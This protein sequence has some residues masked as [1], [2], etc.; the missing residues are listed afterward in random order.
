MSQKRDFVE[1]ASVAGA[2]ISALCREFEVSRQTGHKWLKR[3]K[4]DGY[5]GL[6]EVTRRPLSTPLATAEDVVVAI[7][8][9]R[10]AHP[11]WG[12]RKLVVV[13]RKQLGELAPSERTIARVIERFGQVRKRAKRRALSIV[14]RAPHVEAKSSNDVWTIDFKGWWRTGDG[15]RSEPLTVRD[16]YSRFVLCVRLMPTRGADVRAALEPLFRKHGVPRAIQCDNGTPFIS[17]ASP[18]GLT[19]LSAWWVSLGI[20]VA[21]SRPGCPQ[22]N[23]AHERMHRDMASDL[24]ASPSWDARR[25]QRAC[26]KWRQDF[27]SMRPHEALKGKTP[28]EVYTPRIVRPSVQVPRYQGGWLIRRVL[29]SGHVAVAGQRYSVGCALRGHLVAL[30]PTGGLAHRI[31]FYDLDLGSLELC[32]SDD[33]ISRAMS[34]VA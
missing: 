19:A 16:A 20:A 10:A 18:A 2:N 32:P 4:E 17:S 27:N 5:A 7:V 34:Q 24:Q 25:Q 28:A 8:G 22:D 23:G 6:E 33:L 1:R 3:F 30:E 26:D 13:L 12:P 9:A 15:S 14:E 21:R 11:S 29:K 31:W